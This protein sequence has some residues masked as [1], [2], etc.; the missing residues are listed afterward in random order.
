MK[1]FLPQK[2]SQSYYGLLMSAWFS[3]DIDPQ[4]LLEFTKRITG[5]GTELLCGFLYAFL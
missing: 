1:A 5:N 4:S 3:V 2:P